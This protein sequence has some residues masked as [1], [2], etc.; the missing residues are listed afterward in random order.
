MSLL[1]NEGAITLLPLGG[2]GKG[3]GVLEGVDGVPGK[4]VRRAVGFQ[5]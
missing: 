1:A 4:S 5:K 3:R 2:R